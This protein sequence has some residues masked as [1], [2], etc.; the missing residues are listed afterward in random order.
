VDYDDKVDYVY[1]GDLRGNMWKFDLTDSDY[2]NWEVAFY[3]GADERPLFQA[4]G[5]G[6]TTQPITTKP[7]VMYHP[8]NHGYMVIFSTGKY[9]AESDIADTTVQSFYGI[10][11]YGDDEDDSEYLGSFY[12]GFGQELTNQPSTVSL[13]AQEV[14]PSESPDPNAP[15]FWTVTINAGQPDEYDLLLR[16]TT[17]HDIVWE[18]VSDRN[19]T[20][21]TDPLDDL[22]DSVD[23]HAGWYFDLP[24]SGEK[25]TVD[26]MIRDGNAIAI[27][28]APE[29]TPCGYGGNSVIHE[30]DAENGAR[31]SRPQFDINGDGVID[32]NDRINIGTEEDPIWVVPTGIS[33]PGHLQPPAI[34]IDPDTEVEIKYFSSSSGSIVMVKEKAAK[35]GVCYWREFE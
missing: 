26:M 20:P 30:F 28:F 12:R 31:L 7:D 8:T 16:L 4:Q 15:D 29:D 3:E 22:S 33:Q 27:S 32:E 11:D 35:L 23:N 9:L 24:L 19:S 34:L 13:L 17:D 14:I 25:G 18:T 1:A 6:A 10:W 2:N 21:F 5:P